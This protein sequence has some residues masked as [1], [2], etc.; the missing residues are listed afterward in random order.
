LLFDVR[1]NSTDFARGVEPAN[2]F[3]ARRAT[4]FNYFRARGTRK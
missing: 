3:R 2:Y 4:L 1:K